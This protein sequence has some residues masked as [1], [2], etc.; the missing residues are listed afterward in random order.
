MERNF[1]IFLMNSGAIYN[2]FSHSICIGINDLKQIQNCYAEHFQN[3]S[4][5]D[6]NVNK[7]YEENHEEEEGMPHRIHQ[8]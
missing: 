1:E 4:N 8:S 3:L 2:T 7:N 5:A 6:Q